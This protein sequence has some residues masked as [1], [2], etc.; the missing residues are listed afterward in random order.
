M[1]DTE[2]PSPKVC[3]VASEIETDDQQLKQDSDRAAVLQDEPTQAADRERQL[4]MQLDKMKDDLS[5]LQEWLEQRPNFQKDFDDF[6]RK[7]EMKQCDS[8]FI[9]LK[10]HNLYGSHNCFCIAI[11]STM[12]DFEY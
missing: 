7:Q 4:Q 5:Q 6:R 2:K 1:T 11:C 9:G 3:H 12:H 10:Y 8:R